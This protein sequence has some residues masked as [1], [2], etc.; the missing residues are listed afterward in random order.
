M[1]EILNMQ[2]PITLD[3]F[4]LNFARDQEK[5]I[6]IDKIRDRRRKIA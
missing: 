5:K 4:Y 1:N 6:D 3:S 2:K